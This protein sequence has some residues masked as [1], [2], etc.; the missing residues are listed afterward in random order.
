MGL[1]EDKKA[2][3]RAQLYETAMRLFDERGYEATRI[4]DIIEAGRRVGGHLLQLLPH[5]GRAAR[6]VGRRDQGLLPRLPPAPRGPRDEPT[7]DRIRELVGVVGS[8]VVAQRSL[9]ATVVGGTDLFFGSS[10]AAKELDLENF[11]LMAEIF[12]QGQATGEIDAGRDA[13]QLAE[14]VTS[15]Q[16]LTINN[17]V[18]GWWGDVGPLEPR[19][20]AAV[21]VVLDG[22]LAPASR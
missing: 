22:C 14:I 9:M 15:V 6:P 16:L 5:Q 7:A 10:G 11:D 20:A 12:R 1:R 21:D 2:R 4:S 8:V 13:L 18:T 19:L 3:M 17:W